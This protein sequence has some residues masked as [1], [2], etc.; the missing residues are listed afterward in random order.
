MSDL[1]SSNQS[2][3]DINKL[4]QQASKSI[5]CG[6]ECQKNEKM[7]KLYKAYLDSKTNLISAPQQVET[8]AK[9]YY[10]YAEG[11]KG[12][13]NYLNKSLDEKAETLANVI[14]DTFNNSLNNANSTLELFNGIVVNYN[15]VVEL[16]EK[17]S[18][19]NTILERKYKNEKNDVL[20]ND[21]KTYY[22]NQGIDNL[23]NYYKYLLLFYICI[24]LIYIISLFFIKNNISLIKKSFIIIC[25]I[26]YPFII[27]PLYKFVA[28]Y[29]IIFISMFPIN[30][31]KRL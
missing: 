2:I 20:T 31:Y 7:E 19:E 12:Y 1:S 21:R 26:L 25:L 6:P 28:Y 8:S 22:T 14:E 24:V 30:A 17:Y 18:N 15:S 10:M 11:S 5:M 13:N 29:F 4:L 27:I 9:K 23:N 3:T 16:Y